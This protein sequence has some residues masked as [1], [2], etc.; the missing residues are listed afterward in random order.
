MTKKG[1]SG[2]VCIEQWEVESTAT[3]VTPQTRFRVGSVAKPMTAVAVAQLVDAGRLDVDAPIQT[4]APDF[5][6]KRWP[7]TTR[8]VGAHLGGIRHYRGNE[9]MS[10][11]RYPTVADGLTI[12]AA[13]SLL[14]EPGTAYAYSSYGYNLI[15]AVVEGASGEDFLGYMARVN[16][17]RDGFTGSPNR[18][19]NC[20]DSDQGQTGILVH[21]DIFAK[22]VVRDPGRND[23]HEDADHRE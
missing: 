5:P 21:L 12:F 6:T 1:R 23:D 2:H 7:L 17:F 18:Q 4:Y 14:H 15:S 22:R 19:E 10:N 9:F 20:Q 11:V 16:F 13:D 3:P 8:Q